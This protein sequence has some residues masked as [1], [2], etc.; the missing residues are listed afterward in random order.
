MDGI[1]SPDVHTVM[2]DYQQ[3]FKKQKADAVF[4]ASA[5][6]LKCIFLK[7]LLRRE[8]ILC[9]SVLPQRRRR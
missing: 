5:F 4:T 8:P 6:A 9:Y 2:S 7:E 3:V 1:I